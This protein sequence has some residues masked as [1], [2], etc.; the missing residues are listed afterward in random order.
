[1][2]T[3]PIGFRFAN[4]ICAETLANQNLVGIVGI[5]GKM[6]FSPCYT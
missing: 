3:L 5:V 6:M 4:R 1:M 2:P